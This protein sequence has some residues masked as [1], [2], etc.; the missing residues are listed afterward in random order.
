M[1][2]HG[3][4]LQIFE[5]L[6][7][8]WAAPLEYSVELE[9]TV[10]AAFGVEVLEVSPAATLSDGEA[11]DRGLLAT[12]HAVLAL[13]P[14]TSPEQ[15]LASARNACRALAA[16]RG[17]LAADEA[18]LDPRA[19]EAVPS[20]AR[21]VLLRHG[22]DELAS[23]MEL[24]ALLARLAV[25]EEFTR[26]ALR[27]VRDKLRNLDGEDVG[28]R[29]RSPYVRVLALLVPPD[30][31]FAKLRV[32]GA[33]GQGMRRAVASLTEHIARDVLGAAHWGDG[34]VENVEGGVDRPAIVQC[35]LH[36]SGALA[37]GGGELG[38]SW[39][40]AGALALVLCE[41]R[42]GLVDGLA[43]FARVAEQML[44]RLK[45]G[46]EASEDDGRKVRRFLAVEWERLVA[47]QKA[48]RGYA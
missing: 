8:F 31:A 26:H 34:H 14:S 44:S 16:I 29:R 46:R 7:G 21:G 20:S 24:L 22:D 28:E 36:V 11:Y 48:R 30:C 17:A 1:A 18:P 45:R 4:T 47:A 6:H 33:A 13:H 9:A 3:A 43:A 42:E 19:H 39:A 5:A 35:F 25:Q 37:L 10:A 15:R 40:R 27:D 41:P 38:G 12:R 23:A 2:W 32:S